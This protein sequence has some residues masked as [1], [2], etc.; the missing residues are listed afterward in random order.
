LTDLLSKINARRAIG[1]LPQGLYPTKVMGSAYLQFIEACDELQSAVS[2]RFMD[3][4]H[5]LDDDAEAVSADVKTLTFLD[6]RAE[7]S[8]RA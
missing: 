7:S 1:C 5:F 2:L 4:V 6:A 3:D 8:G